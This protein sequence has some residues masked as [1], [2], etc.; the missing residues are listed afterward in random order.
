MRT[1]GDVISRIKNLVKGVKQDAFLTDRVVFSV[2]MK[3]ARAL[4]RR[5]D[6]ANKVSKFNPVFQ[7]IPFME[8]IEVDKVEAQCSG[9]KADCYI[10]RT[11]YRIPHFISGYWGPLVRSI[12]SIDGS[13]HLQPTYPTTWVNIANQK[14]FRYNTTKYYWFLDGYY[15]FPNLDWDAVRIEGVF[16]DELVE[17]CDE[18]NPP[19]IK[20]KQLQGFY[21][22]D[23]L[24]TEIDKLVMADLGVMFQIPSDNSDDKVNISR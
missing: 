1:I 6:S 16:E 15:Y 10:R 13:E 20:Q 21:I 4:M 5:Q 19:C 3:H 7:V 22:P 18:C 24:D 9:I 2:I 8:L 14:N 23:F 17:Q 12:T 11:K